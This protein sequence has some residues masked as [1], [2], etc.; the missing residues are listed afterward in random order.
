MNKKLVIIAGGAAAIVIGILLWWLF[1]GSATDTVNT[2]KFQLLKDEIVPMRLKIVARSDGSAQIAVKFFDVD[3]KAVGRCELPY[4]GGSITQK[5][6]EVNINGRHVYLPSEMAQSPASP[7]T[8]RQE[9]QQY[10]VKDG[11]PMIYLSQV[12]DAGL[13]DEIRRLYACILDGDIEDY[14]T[15]RLIEVT[16]SDPMERVNYSLSVNANGGV[17]MGN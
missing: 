9:L 16:L 11:F 14:G 7:D 12:A 2:E 13:Q 3:G 5:I 4:A 6:L 15:A 17:R 10:Y 8:L 1:S